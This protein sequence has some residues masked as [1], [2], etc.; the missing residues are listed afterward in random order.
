LVLATCVTCGTELHPER[1]EKYDYCTKPDCVQQ[2]ARGLDMVGVGVNKA[3][4]Q[5]VI[6][7]ERTKREMASGR[8]KKRPEAG[9]S[10]PVAP[11][12]AE[13]RR[14]PNPKPAPKSRPMRPA[15]SETQ[16][17]LALIYRRMGMSPWQI[18]S[19][20]GVTESEATRILLDATA[21][22]RR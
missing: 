19:K 7:D 11:A 12:P 2:N 1:A 17:N 3:A 10:L 20:L 14:V 6:L 22:G 4:E 13:Q 5:Y 21:R 8:F 9:G 16:E 18:A 15:W